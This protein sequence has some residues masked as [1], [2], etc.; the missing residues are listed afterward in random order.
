MDRRVFYNY[1]VA[2]NDGDLKLVGMY[3]WQN[4]NVWEKNSLFL[5]I[6]MQQVMPRFL[7]PTDR[8]VTVAH[9]LGGKRANDKEEAYVSS[10]QSSASKKKMQ[11]A[12]E[13]ETNP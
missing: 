8:P 1:E 6:A 13:K 5:C 4:R 11:V 2:I 10:K 9:S 7:P 3:S 12:M